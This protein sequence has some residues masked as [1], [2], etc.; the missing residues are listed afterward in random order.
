MVAAKPFPFT[1]AQLK[2]VWFYDP[3]SGSCS[4]ATNRPDG[5][6]HTT[7]FKR[8]FLTHRLAWYYMTGRQI[9]EGLTIDHKNRNRSD[10]HWDN[11]RLCTP[12]E[13]IQNRKIAETKTCIN[14][15]E[16]S[17]RWKVRIQSPNKDGRRKIACFGE[18]TRKDLALQAGQLAL[19]EMKSR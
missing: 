7:L 17:K 5:Y 8:Q 14:W 12:A 19:E 6:Q 9:P 10:Q 15:H 2:E 13:Q 16:P 11:L 1:Q 4:K 3:H 18:Y